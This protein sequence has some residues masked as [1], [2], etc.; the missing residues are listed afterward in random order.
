MP[1]C[2]LMETKHLPLALGEG[3]HRALHFLGQLTSDS[4]F[5]GRV[6]CDVT[7]KIAKRRFLGFTDPAANRTHAHTRAN[8]GRA[9]AVRAHASR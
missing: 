9:R 5:L 2:L 7:Y 6:G 3:R 8:P 1:S 4:G